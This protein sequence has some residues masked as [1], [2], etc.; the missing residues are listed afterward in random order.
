MEKV[1]TLISKIVNR[2]TI[3]YLFWGVA[4]SILNVG[5][6]SFLDSWGV[7]YKVANIIAIFVTKLAA[8]FTSK[9]FVFHSHCPDMKAL[10]KEIAAF[11]GARGFT[12][13]VD[14][15]G[16]IVLVDLLR[17]NKTLSK[18]IMTFFVVVLNYF[19]SKLAVF[20]DTD[21]TNNKQTGESR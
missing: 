15:L 13:I 17:A 2:E 1:K 14:Y 7:D 9:F 3:S 8:Y 10:I 12:M 11:I 19:F 16:L 5:L 4:T 18:L 6:F 21:N 20:K